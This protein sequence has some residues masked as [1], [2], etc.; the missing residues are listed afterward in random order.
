MFSPCTSCS[1]RFR[2]TGRTED[3]IFL[4]IPTASHRTFL[5]APGCYALDRQRTAPLERLFITERDVR[6]KHVRTCPNLFEQLCL[7]RE[8][9]RSRSIRK[10]EKVAMAI[11]RRRSAHTSVLTFVRTLKVAFTV[12][13]SIIQITVYRSKRDWSKKTRRNSLERLN[14]IRISTARRPVRYFSRV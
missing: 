5:N 8:R 6:T 2:A 4:R 1:Y 12:T 14:F 3:C 10:T 7:Y 9:A 11:E 13:A